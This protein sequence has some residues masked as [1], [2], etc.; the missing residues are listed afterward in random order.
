MRNQCLLTFPPEIQIL[1]QITDLKLLS[2]LPPHFN[3]PICS[4]V[5][6][7]GQIHKILKE[8]VSGKG[9]SMDLCWVPIL[10]HWIILITQYAQCYYCIVQMR[11][12]TGACLWSHC[13]AVMELEYQL[14]CQSLCSAQSFLN[15]GRTKIPLMQ[16]M[17]ECTL[18]VELGAQYTQSV[19]FRQHGTLFRAFH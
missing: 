17:G 15:F 13:C 18:P 16:E 9:R 1:C 2:S 10:L 19:V 11:L 8:S 14:I 4:R 12:R 3:P 7:L 5:D 6:Y